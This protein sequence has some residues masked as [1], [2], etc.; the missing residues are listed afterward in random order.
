MGIKS[1]ND[2][3]NNSTLNEKS[4]TSSDAA[5]IDQIHK[6]QAKAFEAMDKEYQ[7]ARMASH[8]HRGMG[9]GFATNPVV[10]DPNQIQRAAQ[11]NK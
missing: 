7:F 1:T 3:Q 5:A 4:S 6:M 11:L 2:T 9:L 10:I 8:T